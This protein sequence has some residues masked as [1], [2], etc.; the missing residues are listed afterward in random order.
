MA[1]VSAGTAERIRATLVSGLSWAVF[2]PNDE[3]TWKSVCDSATILL[4][5]F[6][7]R[8]QLVGRT[9]DEAFYV[10][11]GP[12]TMTQQ[13]IDE[14]RLIVVVGVATVAPAEFVVLRIEQMIGR[15]PQP[16]RGRRWRRRG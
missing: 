10:G 16:R 15:Q 14:G 8:G 9:R 13:D 1:G 5:S 11:C 4:D 6:W 2:A 7:R 3:A 12:E